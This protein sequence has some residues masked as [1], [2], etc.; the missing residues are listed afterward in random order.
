MASGIVAGKLNVHWVKTD[1]DNDDSVFCQQLTGDNKD[2]Y[3]LLARECSDREEDTVVYGAEFVSMDKLVDAVYANYGTAVSAP[4]LSVDPSYTSTA[5]VCGNTTLKPGE[6]FE[7][8]DIGDNQ[9]DAQTAASD[10]NAASADETDFSSA[11]QT[12][13][14]DQAAG[15]LQADE[16]VYVPQ[17]DESI[18]F[19][20]LYNQ[21]DDEE[22]KSLTAYF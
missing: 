6:E 7:L 10:I 4:A 13:G 17:V 2:E 16:P 1:Y 18:D 8:A 5:W 21:T 3:P 22:L 11:S 15:S 19:Q 14:S 12:G 9:S 20:S